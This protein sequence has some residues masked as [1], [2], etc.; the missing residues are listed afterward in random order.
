MM[1]CEL[2]WRQIPKLSFLADV[3]FGGVFRCTVDLLDKFGKD[4]VFSTPLTSGCG[5]IHP[6]TDLEKLYD[7]RQE[8]RQQIVAMMS[9]ASSICVNVCSVIS[10]SGVKRPCSRLFLCDTSSR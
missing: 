4:R 3:A 8:R 6:D 7:L 1:L 9:S 5:M 10:C 2:L